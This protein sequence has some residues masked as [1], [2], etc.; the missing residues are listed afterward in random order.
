MR[1]KNN[2]KVIRYFEKRKSELDENM[3]N[4]DVAYIVTRE[5]SIGEIRDFINYIEE[6]YKGE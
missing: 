2:D 6:K 1:W 4:A 3:C 5:L